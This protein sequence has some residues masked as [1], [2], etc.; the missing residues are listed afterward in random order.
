MRGMRATIC[1]GPDLPESEWHVNKLGQRMKNDHSVESVF[2]HW[3]TL[4]GDPR[5]IPPQTS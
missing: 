4:E 5:D 2:H 1:V 3:E